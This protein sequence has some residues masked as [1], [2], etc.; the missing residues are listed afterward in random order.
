MKVLNSIKVKIMAS[1]L[2]L[3]LF[4][5]IANYRNQQ[6]IEDVYQSA[7][8]IKQ[9]MQI[10]D[11]M[12]A[13]VLKTYQDSMRDNKLGMGVGI[14]LSLAS[15]L[16]L[17]A[18]VVVPTSRATRKMNHILDGL[19]HG[20][21]DLEVRI[22]V[23]RQDEIGTLVN[24]INIFMEA[25]QKIIGKIVES[26]RDLTKSMEMVG[27]QVAHANE[28]STDISGIMQELAASME[29]ISNSVSY[30]MEGSSEIKE[31]V[32]SMLDISNRVTLYVEDMKNRAEE[33]RTSSQQKKINI[34][35]V[36]EKIGGQLS[37]A[38]EDGRKADNINEL[39]NQILNI[40][41][42]TN[43]LALNASI[44]A[45][46]AG[47][48]GKGFAVVAD[49]IRQLADSSRQTANNIQELAKTVTGAVSRL[50]ESANE[51]MDYLSQA[52]AGDYEIYAKNGEMYHKD[53]LYIDSIMCEFGT[54]FQ[55]LKSTMDE[56]ADSM[57]AISRSVDESSA[58]ITSIAEN[59]AGLV[60]E[61]Q[62]ISEE[63]T[64]NKDIVLKLQKESNRFVG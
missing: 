11:S 26:T 23:K 18:S 62:T 4:I 59:T 38:I 53:A 15:I 51:V 29:E 8:Q 55:I 12:F 35:H 42:Q 24:G 3:G 60:E 5:I 44:E 19:N 17:S 31:D 21:A 32:E 54:N 10:D 34:D 27:E 9:E 20:R 56:M 50:T 52:V 1:V 57:S 36:I 22:P 25:L 45:A 46:R 28:N 6:F 61:V 64:K 14:V 33:L 16:V 63:V 40:S 58:G 41:S 47:E 39:T 7:F 30:T 2:I 37:I 48:A 49:E 43:L 13:T